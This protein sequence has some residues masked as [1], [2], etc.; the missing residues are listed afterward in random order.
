M[1]DLTVTAANV[2]RVDGGVVKE[3]NAGATIT[4]GQVVYLDTTVNTW[5][6]AQSD[7]TAAEAGSDS[8]TGIA[9][10]GATSGQPLAVQE[11]GTITIGATV[12]I[13]TLYC[14]SAAA[15]GICPYEDLVSTNKIT[16]LGIG[17]TAA[18]INM[19][20]KAAFA[21]GYTGL[22]VP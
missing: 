20:Y 18:R 14:L 8:R 16:I 10:H 6:L 17:S 12:A 15:G 22:A 9:L 3:F 11:T 1:A 21:G 4:A 7:G 19:A 5:K 2:A 13:G